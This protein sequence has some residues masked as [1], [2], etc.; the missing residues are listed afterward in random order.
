MKPMNEQ[1]LELLMQQILLDKLRREWG[2][3][4]NRSFEPFPSSKRHQKQMAEMLADPIPWARKH[5][6]PVWKT[7]LQ[8]VAVLLIV[9]SLAFGTLFAASPTIRAAVKRW[10]VEHFATH[11]TYTYSGEVLTEEMPTFVLTE[12]PDGYV[13]VNTIDRPGFVNYTYKNDGGQP[14]RFS[15]VYMFEGSAA[16]FSTENFTVCET[17]YDGCHATV[18]IS[19]DASNTNTLTWIDEGLNLHFTVDGY[20]SQEELIAIADSIQRK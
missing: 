5:A 18:M 9:C 16:T 15:Y 6:R 11:T 20:F 8:K 12:I 14:F 3:F 10:F 7:V 13:L 2:D 17:E 1:E 19:N 4:V